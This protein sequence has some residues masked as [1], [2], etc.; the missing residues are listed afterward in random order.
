MSKG[1]DPG[2]VLGSFFFTANLF[3]KF[4]DSIKAL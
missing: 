3:S 1:V 4:N 2:G